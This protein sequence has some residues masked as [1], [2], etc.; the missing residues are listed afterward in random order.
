MEDINQVNK[1][2]KEELKNWRKDLKKYSKK[3]NKKA[4]IQTI[5]SFIPFIFIWSIM[6]F[7]YDYSTYLFIL[8]S[9]VNSFFLVRIFI[10]QHDCGHQSFFKTRKLNN[11]FGYLSSVFSFLPYKYWAKTHSFHH[12]H[13]GMLDY[14]TI[15]DL[16]TLTVEEYKN[17][18]TYKKIF[19]RIFRMPLVTFVITPIYYLFIT[20]K[21]PFL[22]F[23]N[24]KKT[25]QDFLLDNTIIFF[26]YLLFGFLIGWK[27]FLVTQ[28]S[29]LF[30][31][32][33]IAFWFFYVQHQH[34][35][36]YKKW[37][38]EW[39][40]LLSAIRGSSYYKLPRLF[41][42]LTGNIGIHH[43]H[44]LSSIIPSYN[45]NKC[46]IENPIFSKYVTTI[47][48]L[49]SLKMVSLKLW[50]EQQSKM[51]SFSEYKKIY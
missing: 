11:F 45:L 14:R 7:I 13:T 18:P 23:E 10:I 1:K 19:Y 27:K 4:I 24:K 43:I 15:G 47:T 46:L 26:S 44:H 29:I 3:N 30:F 16:P 39:N 34:E 38:T 25:V 20:T 36:N 8:L 50:D 2:I 28:F 21:Y 6:V 12:S 17:S 33:I 32:G 41:R 37:K 35:N 42:W 31:F 49:E 5:T 9:I 22:K 48:F 40:F 51:I